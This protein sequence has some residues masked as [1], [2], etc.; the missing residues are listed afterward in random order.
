MNRR[1][2]LAGMLAAAC[3][4]AIIRTPGLLMPVKP[5]L[6]P[7]S[8]SWWVVSWSEE[9]QFGEEIFPGE[10]SG[11][12]PWY[13]GGHI[14]VS[15][16]PKLPDTL[17][18]NGQKFEFGRTIAMEFPKGTSE[19]LRH[20]KPGVARGSERDGALLKAAG[21]LGGGNATLLA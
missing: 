16:T 6:V 1:G 10:F 18:L 17:T 5:A 11:F 20:V 8:T 4:P 13:S 19:G 12:E 7:S 3:A 14:S 2:F 21:L 9:P 15:G